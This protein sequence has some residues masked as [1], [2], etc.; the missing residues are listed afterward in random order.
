MGEISLKSRLPKMRYAISRNGVFFFF[1]IGCFCVKSQYFSMSA[2]RRSSR[3]FAL[4]IISPRRRLIYAPGPPPAY[5]PPWRSCLRRIA[6]RAGAPRK[7]RRE[8][9][10]FVF[11]PCWRRGVS[12]VG[13][14][15]SRV[16]HG[17][18]GKSIKRC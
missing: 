16:Q 3:L 18:P 11:L 10:V 9:L 13:I 14:T 1:L 12:T 5:S 17:N 2:S 7:G 4:E 8:V 6:Y 15:G